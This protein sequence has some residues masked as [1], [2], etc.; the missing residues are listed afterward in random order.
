MTVPCRHE[1]PDSSGR[2]RALRK[3]CLHKDITVE[4]PRA[5]RRDCNKTFIGW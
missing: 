2:R 3:K 5:T 4:G 1:V